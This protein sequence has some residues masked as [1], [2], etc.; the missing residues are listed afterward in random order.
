MVIVLEQYDA[1]VLYVEQIAGTGLQVHEG[2]WPAKRNNLEF[3]SS[4]NE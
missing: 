2:T 3:Y 1:A 4:N